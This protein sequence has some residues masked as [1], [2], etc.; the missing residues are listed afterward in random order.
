M[1]ADAEHAPVATPARWQ[2]PGWY[3]RIGLASWYFIGVLIALG[4]IATIIAATSSIVAPLTLGVLLAVAFLPIVRWLEERS[5]PRAL[6]AV[7]VL[8]GL[9]AFAVALV[10]WMI[11][12]VVGQSGE[13]S[14]VLD[15]AILELRDFADSI[16]VDPE[17]VDRIDSAASG[18]LPAV[19][20]G[21]ASLV[22]SVLDSALGL[23][24]GSLLGAIVMYY[25]LKDGPEM[26]RTWL[27]KAA[28]PDASRRR[29]GERVISDVRNYLRGR[30][31]LAATNGV[32]IGL[33]AV[34]LGVPAAGAIAVVNFV[35]GY[36]PYLGAFIGGAF[37]V[38]MALGDGGITPAVAMLVIS[39]A[40]NIGLENLLEPKLLGDSLNLHP[41]LVLLATALG[42]LVAGMMGLILAAPVT[43]IALD[44]KSELQSTGFFDGP[45]PTSI[46]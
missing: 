5:I 20:G 40:L 24:T 14:A 17:V 25:V 29:L 34:V 8:V 28:D 13:I 21:I 7:I 9:I 4:A 41:L 3:R 30:T 39:V 37:A 26:G 10:W 31:A 23:I 33:G 32:G 6:S 2:L 19:G 1:D 18:A 43:A 38:L 11:S 12:A 44:I 16:A 22:V 36:I 27:D 45:E 42:G 35:G 15:A 46:E